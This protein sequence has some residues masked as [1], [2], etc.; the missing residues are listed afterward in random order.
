MKRTSFVTFGFILMIFASFA[1]T[2]D[3]PGYKNLQILPKDITHQQMDSV[4]HHFNDAL[5]VKC[6]F[7]HVRNDST[8]KMDFPSDANPHKN[9]AREMMKLTDKINDDFFNYT[10]EERT[11]TTQLMVTCYT[12]HHGSTDPAVRAPK[13]EL[14]GQGLGS[15]FRSL[16][17]TTKH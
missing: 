1:F 16:T 13:K 2:E 4:M 12:C 6:S 5:N 11:I 10:G 15:P 8:N 9:K 17:D 7:C 14:P 3:D